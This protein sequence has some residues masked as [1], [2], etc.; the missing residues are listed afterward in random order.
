MRVGDQGAKFRFRFCPVCGT[1]VFHTEEG[2]G[3]SVSVAVGAFADPGFPPPEDSPQL[4]LSMNTCVILMVRYST[5][6]CPPASRTVMVASSKCVP[7]AQFKI[8]AELARS[9]RV[10]VQP[11]QLY[12]G[13]RVGLRNRAS[14][15]VFAH[16]AAGVRT[17]ARVELAN[18]VGL[19]DRPFIFSC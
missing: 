16:Q 3:R 5:G 15:G 8:S 7:W 17:R 2:N 18:C 12:S 13:R 4:M 14:S 9:G 1:T 10:L 11:G 6:V 19:A